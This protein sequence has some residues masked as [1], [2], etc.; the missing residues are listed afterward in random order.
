MLTETNGVTVLDSSQ[1]SVTTVTMMKSPSLARRLEIAH[2]TC[3]MP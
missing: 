2:L 3:P 1:T